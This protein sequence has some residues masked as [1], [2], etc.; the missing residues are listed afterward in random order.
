MDLG[1]MGF[2]GGVLTGLSWRTESNICSQVSEWTQYLEI[3]TD[4]PSVVT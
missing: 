4:W 3:L 1:E 2:G